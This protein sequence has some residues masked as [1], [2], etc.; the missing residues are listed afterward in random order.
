MIA[1]MVKPVSGILFGYPRGS[2]LNGFLQQVTAARL[3]G[4]QP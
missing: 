4:A 1:T 2:S 3:R